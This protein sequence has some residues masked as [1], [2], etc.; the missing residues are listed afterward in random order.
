MGLHPDAAQ[1]YEPYFIW[2]YY[3][4]NGDDDVRTEEYVTQEIYR[5]IRREFERFKQKTGAKVVI[6]KSPENSFR[7]PFIRAIFPDA[8]W[9]HIIRD[10]RA[11]TSSIHKEWLKRKNIVQNRDLGDFLAVFLEMMSLQPFW[12]NRLQAIWFELKNMTSIRPQALLNKSRWKGNIGWG[13]RFPGWQ[14][15]LSRHSQLQFNALQWRKTVER[16]QRD[17]RLVDPE[18]WL[19]IKYEDMIQSSGACFDEIFR[20][21]GLTPCD[22][23]IWD[24]LSDGSMAKWEKA[25][26][27]KQLEEIDEVIAPLQR[28][29]GYYT[30]GCEAVAEKNG[31]LS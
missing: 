14:N 15:A 8:K 20:F 26:T 31:G 11:V 24:V 19:E 3:L 29:L 23:P 12:R 27:P 7:I 30:E 28:R 13:V 16:V 2:D 1:W 22:A 18:N 10:G 5:F 17:S 25:F 9:I 6:E 21:L 4:G